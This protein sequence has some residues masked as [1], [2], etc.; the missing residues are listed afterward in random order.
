[1]NK[2]YPER[3]RRVFVINQ[4]WTLSLLWTVVEPLL[5]P[6]TRKKVTFIKK[7]DVLLN[8]FDKDSLLCDFGGTS[9]INNP[10]NLLGFDTL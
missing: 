3:L 6:N 9:T 8:Y 7:Q 4:P 5:D 2:Y 10:E 1:M